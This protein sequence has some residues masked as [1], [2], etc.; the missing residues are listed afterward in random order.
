[1]LLE[2]R[3]LFSGVTDYLEEMNNLDYISCI[4][5]KIPSFDS[6]LPKNIHDLVLV[7]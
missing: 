6:F 4:R 5:L 3:L 1:M 2:L 7:H